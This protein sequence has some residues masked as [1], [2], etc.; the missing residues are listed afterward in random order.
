[1]LYNF[2][3]IYNIYVQKLFFITNLFFSD[4]NRVCHG[5]SLSLLDE[6]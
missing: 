5:L 1:M 4:G 3:I 2:E 6:H